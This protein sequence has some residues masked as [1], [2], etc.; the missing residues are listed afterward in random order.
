MTPYDLQPGDVFCTASPMLLGRAICAVEAFWSPDGK[1]KYSHAGVITRG[2]DHPVSYEALW[3]NCRQD[4]N[5]AYKGRQVIIGRHQEMNTTHFVMGW[6]G[7]RHLEGKWYAGHRLLLHIFPPLARQFA[8]GGFAVCSELAAKFLF[9]A[10]LLHVW[11]GVTPDY[12]S[13]VIIMHRGWHTIYEGIW[14]G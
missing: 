14:E 1:A 10:G 9:S 4:F 2:G 6:D 12:L 3:T 13:E 8:T 11:Q 5:S 7:V